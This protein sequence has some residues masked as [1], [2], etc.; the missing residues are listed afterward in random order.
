MGFSVSISALRLRDA[1]L[2]DHRSLR[3]GARRSHKG[4]SSSAK[5]QNKASYKRRKQLL[6]GDGGARSSNSVPVDQTGQHAA[7]S[8]F[9]S[10]AVI[11][12]RP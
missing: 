2:T 3:P 11:L 12:I 7:L 4:G 1:V 10:V 8:A 5:S 9:V 6:S